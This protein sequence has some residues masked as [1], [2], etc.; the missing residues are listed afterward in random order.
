MHECPI[1]TEYCLGNESIVW[2]SLYT[3]GSPIE[4]RF[5]GL[6]YV[7]SF[8]QS[9][10]KYLMTTPVQKLSNISADGLF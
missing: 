3:D 5:E 7:L 10:S 1:K 6:P 9:L 2:S 4:I 8:E